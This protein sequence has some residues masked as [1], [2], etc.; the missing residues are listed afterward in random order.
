MSK[1]TVFFLRFELETFVTTDQSLEW[2]NAQFLAVIRDDND[3]GW[4]WQKSIWWNKSKLKAWNQ[5]HLWDP[6]VTC[7]ETP[8]GETEGQIDDN[9]ESQGQEG[10]TDQSD[11]NYFSRL[12]TLW[13]ISCPFVWWTG[14]CKTSS[15]GLK[16]VTSL[17][18]TLVFFL[19][20]SVIGFS[21]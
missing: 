17:S 10:V 7:P 8:P 4:H 13:E 19:Y 5:V 3:N 14:A 16:R 6:W 11:F 18:Q 12:N 21:A 9:N 2:I 1:K 15:E 20:A